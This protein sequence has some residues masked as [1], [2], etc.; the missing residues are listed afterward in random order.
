MLLRVLA[1]RVVT[2]PS[3]HICA[4]VLQVHACMK[5]PAQACPGQTADVPWRCLWI[6]RRLTAVQIRFEDAQK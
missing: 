2:L 4:S 1:V 3:L 6:E 5:C